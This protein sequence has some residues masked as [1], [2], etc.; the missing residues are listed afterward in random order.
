MFQP[1]V[2]LENVVKCY[3]QHIAVN[4]LSLKVPLG[5]IY[6]FIGSN[7]S[8]KTTTIR[9]ILHIIFSDSGIVEVLGR[10]E[11]RVANVSIGY[12]PE[13]RGLYKKLTARRQLAY[14]ADSREATDV[15]GLLRWIFPLRLILTER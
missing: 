13:E 9:L 7:G 6:G 2:S 15:R 11:T 5:S 10:Q 1:A 8:G 3:G 12:L 4:I 14:C